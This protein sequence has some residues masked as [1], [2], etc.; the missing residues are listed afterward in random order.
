MAARLGDHM[1]EV[2][3]VTESRVDAIVVGGV[4]AVGARREYRSER[5]AGRPEFDSVLEPFNDAAQTV[6]VSGRRRFGGVRTDEA[7]RVDLPP[8]GVLDPARLGHDRN[9]AS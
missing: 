4:V 7:Q 6:L 1:V 8:D 2:S 3:V 5:E 9:F